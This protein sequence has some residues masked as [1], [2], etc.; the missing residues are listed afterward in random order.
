ME[1]GAGGRTGARRFAAWRQVADHAL[2]L[3]KPVTRSPSFHS[4]RFFK[5][6]TRSKRF[7]TLRLAPSVLAARKLRCCDIRVSRLFPAVS[8]K[9]AVLLAQTL[10]AAKQYRLA[11]GD[12]D[13]AAGEGQ[14]RC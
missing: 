8:N 11:D 10:W 13:P 3:R 4:P 7:K 5:I 6:S 2:V 1:S 12:P 9:R 14:T